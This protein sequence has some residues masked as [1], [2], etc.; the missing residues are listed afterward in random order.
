MLMLRAGRNCSRQFQF[1]SKNAKATMKPSF[2]QNAAAKT[3]L[4][5]PTENSMH[6]S[7]SHVILS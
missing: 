3:K 2:E 4:K 5:Y 7:R 6:S 1:F